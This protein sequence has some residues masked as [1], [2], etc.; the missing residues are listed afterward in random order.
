MNT[1]RP[2]LYHQLI[3][4][5]IKRIE[6]GE[7]KRGEK[8]PSEK[9][10]GALT[11][12]SR[13][14]VRKAL[15]ELE[16]KGYIETLQGKGSFVSKKLFGQIE[17][18]FIDIMQAIASMG[19]K[20]SIRL[21]SF[22]LIVDGSKKHITNLFEVGKDT[23]IYSIEQLF[24]AGNAPICYLQT[25]LLFERFPMISCKELEQKQLQPFLA[26][27]YGLKDAVFD[28]SYSAGFL[29][30]DHPYLVATQG[31]SYT[32]IET[33]GKEHGKIIYYSV[34]QA[35]GTLPAYLVSKRR[36]SI[37]AEPHILLTR[38]DNRLVHGQVGITWTKTIGANLI[39]VANDE[40]AGEPL[41]QKLM[42]STA[43]SAGAEI[44]FFSLQK[45]I[46]VIGKASDRQ[47]IFIIVRDP[48]DARKLVDGGVPIKEINVGN[49]HFSPGKEEVTKKVYVDEKDKEALSYLAHKDIE[50]YIQ[51]VPGDRKVGIKF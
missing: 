2:P 19:K 40:V 23:Y 41:Q 25:Y 20:P 12:V 7:L 45:T 38:I 3:S 6:S 10:L 13:I 17:F 29:G 9:E 8:L 14:T 34:G 4:E 15:K 18:E 39:L 27:K 32:L 36:R 30:R 1:N 31:N 22:Q 26:Q 28:K 48:E 44:R 37:M 49:M 21:L 33:F 47:K 11:G 43:D 5:I 50:I 51:D 46:D 42:R 24:Y 35:I 16:K